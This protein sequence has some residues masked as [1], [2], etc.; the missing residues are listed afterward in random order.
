MSRAID[1]HRL[2]RIVRDIEILGV[3]AS[4][5]NLGTPQ[6]KL[7]PSLGMPSTASMS[8]EELAKLDRVLTSAE[9]KRV[10]DWQSGQADAMLVAERAKGGPQS[11]T[12]SVTPQGAVIRSLAGVP[13]YQQEAFAG[14]KWWQVILAGVGVGAVG[15]GLIVAFSGSSGPVR[16]YAGAVR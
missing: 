13:W 4:R 16:R 9:Q 12:V 8:P 5:F 7:D 6:L 1:R 11:A 3:E 15:T 2:K 10:S 14:M